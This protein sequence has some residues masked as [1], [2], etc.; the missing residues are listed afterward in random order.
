MSALLKVDNLE[1][2][3][4]AI[5]V[6]RGI[7]FEVEQGGMSTAAA[8]SVILIAIVLAAIG[9]MYLFVG[10]TFASN[11]NVDLTFGGG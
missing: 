11:E 8:Y 6:L 2:S 5:N 9:L 10:R 4:G 7:S 3:Y 1:A